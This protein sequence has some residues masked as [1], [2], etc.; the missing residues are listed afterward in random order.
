MYEHITYEGILDRMLDRVPNRLDKREASVIYDALAP[1]AW[2]LFTMYMQLD[3][4]LNET[5]ADTASWDYLVKRAA[6]RGI[7]PDSA[8]FAVMRGEF[9]IDVPI[10]SRFSLEEYNYTV[11]EKID[12][13][14]YSLR[15]ET[16]GS[17]PNQYLGSLIPI[18][19]IEGL[20]NAQLTEVLI[21][22]ENEEELE[23]L[24]RRYFNSFNSQAFGGNK[25]DYV[26]KVNS[27]DGVGGVKVY[28]V[29]DGGGT[30]KLV[31]INSDYQM[32]STTL[33][34]SVQTQ[35]DPVKNQG[36]GVGIAPIGH[37]VTVTG[38]DKTTVNIEF[39]ITYQTGWTWPDISTAVE[40][41]ID[42]YF[43][44]LSKS[45]EE[46]T[47]LIVRISQIETRLLD[48]EGVLDIANTKINSLEENLQISPD[49]IPVRG[50][51][52]G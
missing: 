26:E 17:N 5:F 25:A 15:A 35:V 28:R 1:A 4:I 41:A 14:V 18:D 30:V 16:V 45:W 9:N 11:I 12:T 48:I 8:T 37:I 23:T 24:R 46:S 10:G 44:E 40:N 42:N 36:E 22:G 7:E 6:E 34:N 49:N 32:P 3:V 31:I 43:Y 20:T 2:E 39:T 52:I 50:D 27:L 21:P 19:Y 29:W 33:I 38:V 13:G 51:V 47:N